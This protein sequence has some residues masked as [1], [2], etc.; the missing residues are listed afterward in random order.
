[1]IRVYYAERDATLYEQYENQ[2]TGIDQIL[3]IAKIASGSILN[4]QVQQNQYLTRFLIDFGS[5]IT[6]ISS[7]ISAGE[8]PEIADHAKSASVHIELKAADASDLLHTYTV[9]TYAVSESWQNGNGNYSDDPIV[10]NGVSWKYRTED[11]SG[12]WDVDNAMGSTSNTQPLDLNTNYTVANGGGTWLTGSDYYEASRVYQN[13]SPDIR[14]DVGH[15]INAWI[16]SSNNTAADGDKQITNN[17]FLFK[18]SDTN[19]NSN[20]ILG[21]IKFFGRESHTIFVP[22]L[23]VSWDDTQF[24]STPGTDEIGSDT[25]VPYF[26]N[27]KDEYRSADIAKFRLGVRPEFPNKRFQTSSFYLTGE[28]LPT[29]SYYSILDSV[30]NE[31]IIP[32]DTQSTQIDCDLNGNFF[33]LRMDSFFPERFYKIML[34]IERSGSTDVQTFDDFYFKVVN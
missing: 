32:F 9:E 3:E 28:K 8:I 14:I 22:K 29:S 18:F 27:I 11:Q 1:M 19:E 5:Q 31:T 12:A 26:K 17:G 16:S 30:T 15:I 24:T 23:L 21:S 20:E 10:K 34:K 6:T 13:E 7:S 33:K 4:G 25:Y 2:N